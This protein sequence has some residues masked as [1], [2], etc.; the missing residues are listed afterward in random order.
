M[1]RELTLDEKYM[2]GRV[3]A[4]PFTGKPGKFERTSN[5]H[6]YALKPF[7]RTVMNELKDANY[8]VVAVGKISDI[9]DGEEVTKAIRTTDNDD[10]MTKMID[11]MTMDFNGLKSLNLVDFDAK[12]G[13]R[14]HRAEYGQAL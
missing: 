14:R 11:S 9:F 4:R 3:I 6:D 2:V 1:A 12:Y 10:V 8:D 7:E 13:H 5:R